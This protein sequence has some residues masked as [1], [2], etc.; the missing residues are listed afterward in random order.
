[1]R[2]FQVLALTLLTAIALELGLI[3]VKL[4]TPTV[5]SVDD[6]LHGC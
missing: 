3:I 4:P 2:Y 5:L 6:L 1:M